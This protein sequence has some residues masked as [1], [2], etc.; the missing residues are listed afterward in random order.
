L[1]VVV[2]GDKTL[3]DSQKNVNTIQKKL[4]YA[5]EG[6]PVSGKVPE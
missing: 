5:K 4:N 3:Q 2:R 1:I 6:V